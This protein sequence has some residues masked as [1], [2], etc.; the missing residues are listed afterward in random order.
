MSP[1]APLDASR[2]LWERL[3]GH[4]LTEEDLEEICE[5]LGRFI[6]L[7]YDWSLNPPVEVTPRPAAGGGR[8]GAPHKKPLTRRRKRT[9]LVVEIYDKE[10]LHE[11]EGPSDDSHL[12]SRGD[13]QAAPHSRRGRGHG[14]A[15]LGGRADRTRTRQA[16]RK[17]S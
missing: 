14:H 12:A 16:A 5:N 2:E 13:A 11:A 15:T 7:L 4:F 6:G 9:I 3:Y 10:G 17:R 8:A 1:P